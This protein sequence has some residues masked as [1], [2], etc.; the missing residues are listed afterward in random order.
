MSPREYFRTPN[1]MGIASELG[2]DHDDVIYPYAGQERYHI[3]GK[4]ATFD[5]YSLFL[6]ESDYYGIPGKSVSSFSDSF[7]KV[8]RPDETVRLHRKIHI[9]SKET[10]DY[11][12]QYFTTDILPMFFDGRKRVYREDEAL[13]RIAHC[14]GVIDENRQSGNC[15]EV[16]KMAASLLRPVMADVISQESADDDVL[17]DMIVGQ[18]GPSWINDFGVLQV[19]VGDYYCDIRLSKSTVDGTMFLVAYY[20]VSRASMRE[21]AYI[22]PVCIRE[23]VSNAEDVV[24]ALMPFVVDAAQQA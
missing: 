10:E 17:C 7:P 23:K 13:S 11:V 21:S 18:Y 4:K 20:G 1:T 9:H 19:Q 12:K 15:N 2:L 24:R 22:A 6:S 5:C 3:D 14:A 8:A 16:I